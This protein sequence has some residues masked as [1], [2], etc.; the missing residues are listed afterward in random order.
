MASMIEEVVD[1]A[2]IGK[3]LLRRF[4]GSKSVLFFP[5]FVSEHV[6]IQLGYSFCLQR[7]V[8]V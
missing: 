1:S 6:S 8:D 2:V 5:V 7:L 4:Y 3:Q